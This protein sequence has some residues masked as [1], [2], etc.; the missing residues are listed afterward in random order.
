MQATNYPQAI[1]LESGAV[2][3]AHYAVQHGHPDVCVM[4]DT[5]VRI[6]IPYTQRMD[7]G[8]VSEGTLLCWS[9]CWDELRM[10]LGY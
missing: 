7:D 2:R 9:S 8:S 6:G 4:T 3:H 1:D 10:A 5:L